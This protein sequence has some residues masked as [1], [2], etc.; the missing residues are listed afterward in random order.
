M[1]LDVA[2]VA[3]AAAPYVVQAVGAYGSAVL[4]KLEE[5]SAS[6]TVGL[7][8]RLLR[9]V[10]RRDESADAVRQAVTELAELPEDADRV[11]VL[12]AELRRAM[13]ADSQ[14]AADVA[15]LLRE[16][17]VTTI[18]TGDR[19]VAVKNNSGIV[20]TGDGSAAWQGPGPR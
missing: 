17:G 2:V 6:A 8:G 15:E 11:S 16:S 7:G 19:A 14:L 1:S 13:G 10:L 4:S 5:A 9:R 3:A 18:V 20:Q 12:R